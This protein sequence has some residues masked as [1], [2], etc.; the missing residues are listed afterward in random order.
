[1]ERARSVNSVR[2][3]RVVPVVCKDTF[4]CG[5]T[6][7]EMYVDCCVMLVAW[8]REKRATGVCVATCILSKIG[9]T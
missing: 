7:E 8:N 6:V 5:W 2:E 3:K 4:L 1:V 9:D